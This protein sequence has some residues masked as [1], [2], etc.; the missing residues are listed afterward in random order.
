MTEKTSEVVLIFCNAPDAA[1]A[2]RIAQHLVEQQL[3]ACVNVLAPCLSTYR[4]AGK[5]ECT[6]E[7]PLL[8]KSTRAAYPRVE[9]AVR[10]LHPY[11][12][13]E[14]MVTQISGG[15]PAYLDWVLSG[16]VQ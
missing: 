16:V 8:I 4:W 1:C 2:Q 15:L 3:A 12:V 9:E 11:E 10:A 7:V 5:V 6:T 14:L 13:P